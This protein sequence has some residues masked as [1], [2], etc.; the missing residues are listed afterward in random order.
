[1]VRRPAPEFEGQTWWGN[2]F[3][4]ISLSNF[5]GKWVVLFYYPLN[6]TFVCPTEIVQYNDLSDKFA[7]ISKIYKMKK[8]VR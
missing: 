1:M 5:F 2:E 8:I 7:E 6:F 4:K 3:K